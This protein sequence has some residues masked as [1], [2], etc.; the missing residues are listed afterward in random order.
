M[1]TKKLPKAD[2]TTKSGMFFNIGLVISISLALF[3]FNYKVYERESIFNASTLDINVEEM[4]EIPITN[5]TPPPPPIEQPIIKEMPNEIEVD[6]FEFVIDVDVPDEIV[7]SDIEI[8]PPPIEDVETIFDI[9]ESAP[10]PAGGMSAWNEY[11][12][13]NLKYPTQARRMGIEGTVIVVFVVNIDGSIQDLEV[14][15]GIGGGCDEEAL[16]VIKNAPKWEPGKQ[17]G[18]PVRVRMRMPVRFKLG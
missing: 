9:V 8:A 12:Q 15:R 17:R 10:L 4:I 16:R 3:A 7:I 13:K 11:L 5:Q 2:L 18:K 6:K 14:L 1:E